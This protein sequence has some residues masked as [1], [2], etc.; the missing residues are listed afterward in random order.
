LT[1]ADV[2]V[3]LGTQTTYE[4]QA[5]VQNGPCTSV[6]GPKIAT[7]VVNPI[8]PQPIITP[9]GPTTFCFGGSVTLSSSTVNAAAYQ[10]FKNGVAIVGATAQTYLINS[11][12]Q[13]GSYTV[14]TV[15]AAPSNCLSA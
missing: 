5:V 9:S 14:Q 7:V 10:W 13:S 4:Y 11:L 3:L 12:A 8:P 15:G 6:V 1:A 2:P